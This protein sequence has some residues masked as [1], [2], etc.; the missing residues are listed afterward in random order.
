MA[1]GDRTTGH[2]AKAEGTRRPTKSKGGLTRHASSTAQEIVI[3]QNPAIDILSR[4]KGAADSQAGPASVEDQHN[5]VLGCRTTEVALHLMSQIIGLDHPQHEETMSSTQVDTM[6]K[7][8]TAMLAELQPTT[9]TEAMLATQMVGAHHAAMLFVTC[10]T[11]PTDTDEGRDRNVLRAL[12]LMRLFT[13]Q[14]E[15]MAKLKGKSSQQRVV[16][17]HVTVQ[18]GGQ[19]LVGAVNTGGMRGT[20]GD[21]PR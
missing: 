8:A 4:L 18:A 7:K 16:V 19:A 9:A 10:A 15:A 3:R 2:G 11:K 6:F 17:E 1:A 20:S 12:R 14:V 21:D 13:E 5:A